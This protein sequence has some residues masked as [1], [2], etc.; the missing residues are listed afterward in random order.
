[1]RA[2]RRAGQHESS[3][4]G[5]RHGL[6]IPVESGGVFFCDSPAHARADAWQPPGGVD[7]IQT[8]RSRQSARNNTMNIKARFAVTLGPSREGIVWSTTFTGTRENL[9]ASGIVTLQQFPQH[10]KAR[11]SSNGGHPESGR[12]Y[13]WQEQPLDDI[14]SVT[15]YTDGIFEDLDLDELRQLQRHL[16]ND[17]QIT[18]ETIGTIVQHWRRRLNESSAHPAAGRAGAA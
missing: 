14:W 4:A 9:V 12:W 6:S 3:P 18:P 1:M 5:I 10:T 16:L 8:T 17:L 15:Y 2:A 13:L 7:K 11:S